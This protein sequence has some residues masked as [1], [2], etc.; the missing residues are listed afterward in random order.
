MTCTYIYGIHSR[1]PDIIT[2]ATVNA[3]VT[4]DDA[5]DP[6]KRHAINCVSLAKN[7]PPPQH[8]CATQKEALQGG[9]P[10]KH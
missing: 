1:T 8:Y 2:Y 4:K 6:S 5:R 7:Y 10:E 9:Y 3:G